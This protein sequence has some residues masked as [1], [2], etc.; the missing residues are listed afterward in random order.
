M[1]QKH[2]L[3]GLIP[4]DSTQPA[5]Q[6]GAEGRS[7]EQPWQ[8]GPIALEAQ[9]NQATEQLR[10]AGRSATATPTPLPGSSNRASALQERR[11]RCSPADPVDRPGRPPGH[12]RGAGDGWP[13]R[14]RAVIEAQ[15]CAQKG[16]C[17]GDQQ[18]QGQQ[19]KFHQTNG[20]HATRRVSDQ[21]KA[22]RRSWACFGRGAVICWARRQKSAPFQLPSGLRMCRSALAMVPAATGPS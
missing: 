21:A 6:H 11:W 16:C 22:F 15:P 8:H 9:G 18:G 7:G 1:G 4:F 10:A 20:P 17:H 14:E 2:F 5:S 19:T 3:V 12:H 13:Q